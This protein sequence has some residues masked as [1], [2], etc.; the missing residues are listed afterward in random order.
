M[1][2]INDGEFEPGVMYQTDEQIQEWL[3]GVVASDN[4]CTGTAAMLPEDLGGVVDTTLTVYGT[5]NVRV[6]GEWYTVKVEGH[7]I[8]LII[9]CARCLDCPF[10][11]QC[12][13]RK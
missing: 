9:W 6:V 4:H 11:A 10:P 8:Q 5:S 7:H 3:R 12:T 2:A 1:D 13:Y